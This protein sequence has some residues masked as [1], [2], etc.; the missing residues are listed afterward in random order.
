MAE[1]IQSIELQEAAAPKVNEGYRI[2]KVISGRWINIIGLVII[3]AFII[4]AVFAPFI[5]PYDPDAQDL[6]AILKKI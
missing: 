1:K 3:A 5:A 6:K 4:V 2:L